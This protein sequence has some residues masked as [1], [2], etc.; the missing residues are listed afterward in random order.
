MNMQGLNSS[1]R[2]RAESKSPD[3]AFCQCAKSG[4]SGMRATGVL[5]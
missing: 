2:I 1:I 3:F 4:H 5:S